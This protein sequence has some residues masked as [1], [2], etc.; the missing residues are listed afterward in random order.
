MIE[1]EKTT[2]DAAIP[3]LNDL[4]IVQAGK[5]LRE[6]SITA[7][8]LA[9]DALARISVLDDR[10]NSFITVTTDR[11]LAD[12]D[13]AD[14]DFANGVDRGPMQGI[15]YALKDIFNT[16]GIR[17]TCHSRLLRDHVPDTDCVVA[18]KL[19]G[20]GGVLIGKTA[21]HELVFRLRRRSCRRFCADGDWLRYR[22]IDPRTSRVLRHD[23]AEADL[24]P[25]VAT[26]RVSVV[27]HSRP[28][29]T[30]FAHRRGYRS[31]H[32]GYRRIRPA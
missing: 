5:L 26:R 32:A 23:R 24:W 9:E 19:R 12:A 1:N 4:S 6:G 25:C 14:T 30:A 3:P 21:T 28:C 2:P 17:T 22:R 20:A 13:A 29:R 8:D 27:L 7:K 10:L 16:A 31:R 18:D 15:P 11:A